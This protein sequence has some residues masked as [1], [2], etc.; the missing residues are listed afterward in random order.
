V[1][2]R[3]ASYKIPGVKVDGN[4]PVA[5]WRTAKL[6]IDRARA[7]EGP[8]LIEATTFRFHGH[9]LGDMDEYMAPGEKQNWLAKDPVPALRTSIL[10]NNYATE[11]RLRDIE[12]TITRDLDDAVEFALASEYADP[13]ELGRDV[14]KHEIRARPIEPMEI[15]K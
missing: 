13:A 3:A 2:D 7:G 11:A 12:A 4:D 10:S 14:F 5:M 1:A 8:T 15:A 6:A 9:L